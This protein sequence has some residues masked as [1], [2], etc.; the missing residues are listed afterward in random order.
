MAVQPNLGRVGEVGADLLDHG[1]RRDGLPE[2]TTEL[3]HLAADL[4]VGN[5]G[6]EV[7]PVDAGQVEGDVTVQDLVD[8]DHTRH[9]TSVDARGR[10]CPSDNSVGHRVA[11][12]GAGGRS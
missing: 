1:G 10:A 2:V 5:V 4:E 8:V 3:L 7:E 9:D 11:S 12:E 6:V